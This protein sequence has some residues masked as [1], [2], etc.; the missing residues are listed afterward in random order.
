MKQESLYRRLGGYDALAAVTDDFIGRL[1]TDKQVGHFFGGHSKD[2]LGRIRQ[3]IVDQLCAATGGPCIYIGRSMKVAH[4]GLNITESDWE[5]SVNHLVATLD[6]FKVPQKE[7]DEVLAAIS[8]MKA[9][10]V[11][12]APMKKQ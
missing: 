8:S 1:A 2:S 3:L 12:P 10:I 6:K 11:A 9:D 5:V 4:E 7:K